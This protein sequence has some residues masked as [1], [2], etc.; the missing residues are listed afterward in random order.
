MTGVGAH[1][2]IVESPST[3]S[4][5]PTPESTITEVFEVYR[6]R[7]IDLKKDKRLVH[8]I[9]FKNVGRPPAPAWSTPTAS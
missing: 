7:L 2:V 5:S 6:D 9:L 1:E 8:G 3:W 4:A